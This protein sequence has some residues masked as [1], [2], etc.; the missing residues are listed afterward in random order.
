[1]T[2]NSQK[3]RIYSRQTIVENIGDRPDSGE[4]DE[5]ESRINRHSLTSYRQPEEKEILRSTRPPDEAPAEHQLEAA[6]QPDRSSSRE[7]RVLEGAAEPYLQRK[8]WRKRKYGCQTS[9]ENWI[10][11]FH[12]IPADYHVKIA[13]NTSILI[14]EHRETRRIGRTT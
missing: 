8:T 2:N 3:N 14:F 10:R 11:K 6:E 5:D 7:T 12:S 1:M 13:E 4:S 9:K